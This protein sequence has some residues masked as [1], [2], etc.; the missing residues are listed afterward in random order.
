MS[1]LD[2]EIARIAALRGRSMAEV[3]ELQA[4]QALEQR[5]IP[6]SAIDQLFSP[7]VDPWADM[8]AYDELPAALRAC[9]REAQTIKPMNATM[10]LELLAQGK[11][12]DAIVGAVR[13]RLS[14]T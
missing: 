2:E 10:A 14:A 4:R 3:G 11:G 8:L 5:R 7:H 12:V 9:F 6:W 1:D 13:Q